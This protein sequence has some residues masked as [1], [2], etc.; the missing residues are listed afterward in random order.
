MNQIA[1]DKEI[2]TNLI[3]EGVIFKRT[4]FFKEWT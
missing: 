1:L 2:K 3:R 4:K